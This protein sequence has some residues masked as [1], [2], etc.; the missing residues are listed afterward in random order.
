M[1]RRTTIA[2]LLMLGIWWSWV[3]GQQARVEADAAASVAETVAAAA[4]PAPPA[5]P[6]VLA[7]PLAA[8]KD[9][10]GCGIA[11]QW[12]PVGPR[13][14][15]AELERWKSPFVQVPWWSYAWGRLTGSLS[16]PW[17]PYG[18]PPG[19]MMVL[20]PKAEALGLSLGGL[21][22]ANATEHEGGWRATTPDGLVVDMALTPKG[23]GHACRLA[24]HVEIANPS[25]RPYTGPVEI[26]LHD[27]V[28]VAGGGLLSG[29]VPTM[30]PVASVDGG[31]ERADAAA[32]VDEPWSPEGTVAWFGLAD[33]YFSALVLPRGDTLPGAVTF[34][35]KAI[36]DT[37]TW[38]G[39]RWK[40][41]LALAA[42]ASRAL[43]FDVFVGPLDPDVLVEVDKDLTELIDFGWF[44]VFAW[45]LAF[46][47]RQ[48]HGLTG[49]WGLAI[50]AL[51]FVLKIIF[52]WPT[53]SAFLAGQAM[54]AVQPEMKAL[55]EQYKD[56]PEELNR[57]IM[58]LFRDRK[59]NPLGGCLPMF[60]Q[61]P[62]W[63]ALY[64][65]LRS[66]VD[67]YHTPFLYL[68]DLSV[69]DPY[70]ALPI[71]VIIAMVIQQRSIPL[72]NMDPAQQQ[73]LRWMPVIFG[74]FFF[75][76]PSG[77]MVYM[78]VNTTLSMAQQWYMKR[79][80]PALGPQT[81]TGSVG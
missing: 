27:V 61:M 71:L 5:P 4:P 70:G 1:D 54:Q 38:A 46:G 42:G 26:S 72:G 50:I 31:V 14:S 43:D 59:V 33:T 7:G 75:G 53:R 24:W 23:T 74:V 6:V 76:L 22:L 73:V 2:V 48:L 21:A 32:I 69:A 11:A 56:Q 80:T 58:E 41:D 29:Y 10:E 34:D 8:S 51:T 45:P 36:D 15:S 12:S 63:I 3:S 65:V 17:Q 62:V 79:G 44:A 81:A 39:V 67:L 66:V 40:A 47:L 28:P 18:P 16:G 52:Y 9:L 78:F 55:Q 60:I 68:Q 37:H 19:R 13:L 64:N 57:R 20:G 77:L 49:D 30:V 35:G 25:G